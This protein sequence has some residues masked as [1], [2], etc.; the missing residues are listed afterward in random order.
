VLGV[1][2][3]KQVSDIKKAVGLIRLP[4]KIER[5]RYRKALKKNNLHPSFKSVNGEARKVVS[6]VCHVPLL[7]SSLAGLLV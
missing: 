1:S 4:P 2:V 6:F 5:Y 7:F 3:V